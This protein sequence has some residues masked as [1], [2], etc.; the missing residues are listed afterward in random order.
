[1]QLRFISVLLNDV[2]INGI[3]TPTA[4]YVAYVWNGLDYADYVTLLQKS[5]N[6]KVKTHEIYAEY[7]KKISAK[8]TICYLKQY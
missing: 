1:M 6:K 2:T 4:K 3:E 5:P 8:M 7:K